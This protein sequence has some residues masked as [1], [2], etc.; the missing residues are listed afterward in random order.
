MGTLGQDWLGMGVPGIPWAGRD[1]LSPWLRL[2]G[3]AA[4]KLWTDFADKLIYGVCL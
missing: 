2:I 1:W 4:G 3:R